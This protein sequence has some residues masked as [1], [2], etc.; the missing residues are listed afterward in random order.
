M[1][2]RSV[3]MLALTNILSNRSQIRIVQQRKYVCKMRKIYPNQLSQKSFHTSVNCANRENKSTAKIPLLSVQDAIDIDL[4]KNEIVKISGWVKSIRKMGKKTTFMD[5]IDGLS[6]HRI[7]IVTDSKSISDNIS[8]HSAITVVGTVVKS[9]YKGQEVE[10]HASDVILVNATQLEHST[11]LQS[12][13]KPNEDDEIINESDMSNLAYPFNPRKRYPDNF[14][15]MYPEFRS[16][17]ADFGSVLRIR[18]AVTHAIND[19]FHK[20]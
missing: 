17:L 19:F 7:Q 11:E 12:I 14:C 1:V 18:S 9:K 13:E 2:P 4:S 5:L 6:S 3:K 16:K 15:R 20:R 8:Y 10:L